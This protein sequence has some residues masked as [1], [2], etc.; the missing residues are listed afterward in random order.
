MNMNFVGRVD[1]GTSAGP[2]VAVRACDGAVSGTAVKG[3][4][5]G[6]LEAG[7][8]EGSTFPPDWA[9]QVPAVHADVQR[10]AALAGSGVRSDDP[11]GIGTDVTASTKDRCQTVYGQR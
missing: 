5:N 10:T 4:E 8:P 1:H 11:V 3:Y 9:L 2:A 7:L 6:V